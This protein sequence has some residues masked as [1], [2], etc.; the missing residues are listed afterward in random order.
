MPRD[1]RIADGLASPALDVRMILILAGS[2]LLMLALVLGVTFWFFR[3]HAPHEIVIVPQLFP[4]PRLMQDETTL[5]RQVQ[6]EQRKRLSQ[7]T[8]VDRDAG[9][10]SVPIEA[11]MHALTRRDD[12]YAPLTGAPASGGA[13]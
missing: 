6:A 8:W 7:W 1:D 13:Q 3:W 12:P 2:A 9:I 5:L 10:A 11:A 4:Q